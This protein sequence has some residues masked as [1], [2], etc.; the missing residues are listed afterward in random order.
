[1]H[2]EYVHYLGK[3]GNRSAYAR[4]EKSYISSGT[5]FLA[6]KPI[7][8]KRNSVLIPTPA[9]IIYCVE[10]HILRLSTSLRVVV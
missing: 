8:Y 7:L 9:T 3:L 4:L 10:H 5:A 1:M 2:A 6:L